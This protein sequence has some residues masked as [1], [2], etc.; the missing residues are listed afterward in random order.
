ME[1]NLAIIQGPDSS[2]SPPPSRRRI[3]R[4]VLPTRVS[5]ACERCRLHKSRCDPYWPCSL[6]VRANVDCRQRPVAQP[7]RRTLRQ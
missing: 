2:V 4:A 3:S 7:R 5:S 1:A 6:C